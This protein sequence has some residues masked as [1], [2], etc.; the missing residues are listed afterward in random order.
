MGFRLRFRRSIKIL[1]GVKWNISKGGS[2]LTFGGRG[3]RHT[4]GKRGARTT[5]GIPGT[6][7]SYTKLHRPSATSPPPLPSFDHAAT[8]RERMQRSFY[9]AGVVLIVIW[10]LGILLE[11]SPSKRAPGVASP[12]ATA[13]IITPSPDAPAST[14][15]ATVAPA[16]PIFSPA[17]AAKPVSNAQV[18]RAVLA[19]KG[20]RLLKPGT[21]PSGRAAARQRREVPKLVFRPKPAVPYRA[22]KLRQSISGQFRVEFGSDGRVIDVK[23]LQSTRNAALDSSAVGTLKLWR[24]EPGENWN[25]NVLVTFDARR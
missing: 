2:S 25:T 18:P 22:G 4:I 11:T 5:V 1:P 14:I 3:F 24:C 6:G 17:I 19:R 13:P 10:L 7:V 15:V 21:T 8:R 23:T 9:I 12:A 20:G 16:A